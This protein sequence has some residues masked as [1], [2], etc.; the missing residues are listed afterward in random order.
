MAV[1]NFQNVFRNLKLTTHDYFDRLEYVVNQRNIEFK[2]SIKLM[3][4]VLILI[5]V[6]LSVTK[7]YIH[8]KYTILKPND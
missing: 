6:M 5:H 3:V 1:S 7:S 8:P 4:L 2:S